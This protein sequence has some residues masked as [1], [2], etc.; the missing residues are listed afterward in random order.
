M[1]VKLFSREGLSLVTTVLSVQI[2]DKTFKRSVTVTEQKAEI[3][4]LIITLLS[5]HIYDKTLRGSGS[6]T[7][8]KACMHAVPGS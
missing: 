8:Q 7:E 5:M 1:K 6:V 3:L 4:S 2:Y